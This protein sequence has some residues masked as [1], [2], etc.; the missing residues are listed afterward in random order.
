MYKVFGNEERGCIGMRI[1]NLKY[2]TLISGKKGKI[3]YGIT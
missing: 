3:F 1:I 2:V